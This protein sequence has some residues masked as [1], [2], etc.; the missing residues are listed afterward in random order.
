ME[1]KT[2]RKRYRLILIPVIA[3][4]MLFGMC[5]TAWAATILEV[6]GT[7][8][9]DSAESAEGF[10][11]SYKRSPRTLTLNGFSYSGNI[12]GIKYSGE[13]DLNIVLTG[14]N[15]ISCN[16]GYSGIFVS[17]NANLNFSG[18]GSLSVSSDGDL[19]TS[20]PTA[21][22]SKFTGNITIK[23]GTVTAAGHW[24]GIQ[25]VGGK[26]I[27]EGG[28][29]TAEGNEC[30]IISDSGVVEI[31]AGSVNATGGKYGIASPNISITGGTVT[32]TGGNTDNGCGILGGGGGSGTVTINGGKVTATGYA[33]GI[34]ATD[35]V[36]ISGGTVAAT[37]T[38]TSG[39]SY[40]IK[41]RD[42]NTSIIGNNTL[43]TAVGAGAAISGTVKNEIKGFGWTDTAGT[44]DKAEID[45]NATGQTLGSYK[46]LRFPQILD[47]ATVTTKPAAKSLTYTGSA[48]ELVTAG[49]A[50]GGQMLYAIGTSTVTAPADGWK[51]SVPTGTDAKTYHVWYMAKGDENHSDSKP[52]PVDVT[53][54][55]V[56]PEPP[57]PPVPP[58]PPAPEPTPS[59]ADSTD[60]LMNSEFRLSWSGRKMKAAWGSAPGADSYEVWAAPYGTSAFEKVCTV[61]AN[62]AT[63]KSLKGKKLSRKKCVKAY[64]VAMRAGTEIGRTFIGHTAGP[65]NRHTNAKKITVSKTAYNLPVGQTEKIQAKIVKA[66]KGRKLLHGNTLVYASS[67]PAIAAVSADGTISAVGAG[68]CEVWIYA[69][70][71]KRQKLTVVVN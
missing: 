61:Q 43:V 1:Q 17:T 9:V 62:K 13:D 64:V 53:I 3:A 63:I 49:R 59:I 10:G 32:A 45:I 2:E 33:Q 39:N 50:E 68:S 36:T 51:T 48:Q 26:I 69:L 6:R 58:T 57:A 52:V 16:E 5:T 22:Y 30:G 47:P 20:S 25:S 18:S 31:G 4:M 70:N 41:A 65:E 46:K 37:A 8:V 34:Y 19:S 24:R 28:N 15:T 44:Q 54:S 27:I 14:A 7:N 21:I 11:W 29:L 60:I 55:E 23:S 71:G 56:P 35:T 67:N 40:G 66:K 12:N 38:G 42:K